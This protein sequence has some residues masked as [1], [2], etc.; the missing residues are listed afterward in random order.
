MRSLDIVG[1]IR[2]D[3]PI[4]SRDFWEELVDGG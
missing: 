2:C 1:M 3:V 4:V